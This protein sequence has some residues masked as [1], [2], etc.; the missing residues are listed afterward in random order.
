MASNETV[1]FNGIKFRR[2]P[3]ADTRSARVYYV[4]SGNHR[5]AGIGRL[6]QEIWKAAHGPIPEGYHVHHA[7]HDPLNNDLSNLVLL[8][9]DEH[10]KHHGNQPDNAE[11]LRAVQPLGQE[12][13]KEWHRSDEGR[14]WHVEHGKRCWEG[15][16]P[17]THACDYC[18]KEYESLLTKKN[19]TRFCSNNCKTQWRRVA[20]IDNVDKSCA[21]CGSTFR[22][23]KYAKVTTCSK[24]CASQRA[25][26]A[27]A[28]RRA[29]RLASLP[30]AA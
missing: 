18:G 29:E 9:A 4:P 17:V 19:V 12:A 22:S 26:R 23:N 13:A 10:L 27:R 8:D 24:P 11:R 30:A 1:I 6:H 20:G 3:D 25:N 21:E 2:Y 7:D 16:E 5:K 28:L 15:R 14:A